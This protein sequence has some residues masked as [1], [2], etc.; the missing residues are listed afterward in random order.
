MKDSLLRTEHTT[1]HLI[2]KHGVVSAQKE[3]RPHPASHGVCPVSTARTKYRVH[4]RVHKFNSHNSQCNK[5][6][7]CLLRRK[8][9]VNFN[10]KYSV[11][12]FCHCEETN[13]RISAER[14]EQ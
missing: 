9:P 8:W 5:E 4:K 2:Y 13:L 14:H 12:F 11:H 6:K 1:D 7:L 10:R 3:D